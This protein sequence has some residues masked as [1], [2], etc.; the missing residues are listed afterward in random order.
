[1]VLTNTAIPMLSLTSS[2][3]DAPDRTPPSNPSTKPAYTSASSK[4][5]NAQA[6]LGSTADPPH[7][8]ADASQTHAGS[9]ADAVMHRPPPSA[10]R[11]SRFHAPRAMSAAYRDGSQIKP[12]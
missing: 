12:S 9:C 7:P 4:A 3:S 8:P 2:P 5:A 6:V 10:R 11:T 1:M